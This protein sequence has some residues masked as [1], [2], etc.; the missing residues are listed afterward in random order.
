VFVLRVAAGSGAEAA[1]LRAAEVRGNSV[2]PGDVIIAVD[3][4]KVTNVAELL[5]RLDDRRVGDT[6]KLRIWRDGEELEVAATLKAAERSAA[7]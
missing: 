2:I 7:V 3:G 4:V 5:S 1:G 6:V